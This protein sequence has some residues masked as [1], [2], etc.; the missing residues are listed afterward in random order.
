MGYLNCPGI[1][2][3]VQRLSDRG[4]RMADRGVSLD[5]LTGVEILIGVDY[6]SQFVRRQRRAMGV[7]L[8]V[9]EEGVM[10]FGPVPKWA[11]G[12]L[13]SNNQFRCARVICEEVPGVTKLWELESI[14][15]TKE[16]MLPSEKEAVSLVKSQAVKTD[17]GYS[18]KLLFK[19]DMRLS[20][21]YRTAR[22]QL[23]YLA[24]KAE[25]NEEFYDQYN[26]VVEGYL[27]RDFIKEVS[28]EDISGH[29]TPHHG[30][31]KQSATTPLRIVFNDSSKPKGGV[32]LNDCL[33]TGL[34]LTAKLHGILLK[35]RESKYAGTADIS[36][37][38]H[39][40]QIDESDR[41]Y[42]KFLWFEKDQPKF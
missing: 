23:R 34:S 25:V 3:V 32:S 31:Y 28:S 19:D 18:V 37:V 27:E 9:T 20:V 42:L 33:L 15:I 35:F 4:F 6:F 12:Q 38:F 5:M 10:T 8:F 11:G 39:C 13:S 1:Y 22:G 36:K 7:N 14:G 21:D 16:V 30:V 41:R 2:N 26:K 29:Y 24:Q 40:V 17:S